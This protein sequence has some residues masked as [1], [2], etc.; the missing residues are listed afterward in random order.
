MEGDQNIDIFPPALMNT[1]VRIDALSSVV[2]IQWVEKTAGT[3]E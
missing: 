2:L 1:I 3:Y